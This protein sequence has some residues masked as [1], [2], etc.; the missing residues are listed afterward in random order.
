V[1]VVVVVVDRE[2][3]WGCHGGELM[4]Y[5]SCDLRTDDVMRHFWNMTS[6]D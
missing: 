5:V 3:S 1:V 4:W 6:R 2:E